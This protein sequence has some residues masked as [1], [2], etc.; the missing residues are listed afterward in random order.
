MV[1]L[2]QQF[3]KKLNTVTTWVKNSTPKRNETI[4][5]PKNMYGNVQNSIIQNS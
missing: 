4:H 2:L 3:L 1:W 5:L